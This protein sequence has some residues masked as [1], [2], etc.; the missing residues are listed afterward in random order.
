MDLI[1]NKLTNSIAYIDDILTFSKTFEEHIEHLESLLKKLKE[2]YMKVKTV[3]CKKARK[4]TMLNGY[5]ISEKGIKIVESRVKVIKE[6]PKPKTCKQ[7]KQFLGLASYYRQFIPDFSDIVD[8]LNKLTP[9][10]VRFKLDE[11][12]SKSYILPNFEGDEFLQK[13]PEMIFDGVRSP[14]E[15]QD[16]IK[17]KLTKET[18]KITESTGSSPVDQCKKEQ[19]E[20]DSQEI[21]S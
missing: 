19:K 7:V 12:C 3:K 9:K 4:T 13:R 20:E 17:P 14:V 5:K 10:D 11:N 16:R 15:S 18:L 8:A 21:F 2:T 6:Y 1:L